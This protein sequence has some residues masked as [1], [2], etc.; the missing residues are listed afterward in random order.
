MKVKKTHEKNGAQ[1]S[2]SRSILVTTA[3]LDLGRFGYTFLS[4]NVYHR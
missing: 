2:W 1:A 4:S 3:V